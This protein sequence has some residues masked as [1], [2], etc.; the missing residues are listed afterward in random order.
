MSH[1]RVLAALLVLVGCL[2]VGVVAGGSYYL[3]YRSISSAYQE[4]D[5]AP[6]VYQLTDEQV[7]ELVRVWCIGNEKC[8]PEWM[9]QP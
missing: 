5:P 8:N 2:A 6:D 1:D 3:G 4:R 7:R 9:V